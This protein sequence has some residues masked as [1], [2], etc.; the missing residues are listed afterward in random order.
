MLE[1]ES[2]PADVNPLHGFRILES[3][4]YRL[5]SRV[6]LLA[7]RGAFSPFAEVRCEAIVEDGVAWSSRLRFPMVVRTVPVP[8]S[9]AVLRT[10]VGTSRRLIVELP[11]AIP[12]ATRRERETVGFAI[13]VCDGDRLIRYRLPLGLD[14]FEEPYTELH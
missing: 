3:A 6:T 11:R 8:T 2:A 7:D 4:P 5:G 14:V 1:L 9:W 12:A 13:S 10:I